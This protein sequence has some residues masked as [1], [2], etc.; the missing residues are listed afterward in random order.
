M[1]MVNRKPKADGKRRD[2]EI[3]LFKEDIETYFKCEVL[4]LPPNAW[5]DTK[6]NKIGY[7]IPF[8][9]HFTNM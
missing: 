7:K 4:L 2:N 5:M 8:T 6:K 9:H 1:K 3:V